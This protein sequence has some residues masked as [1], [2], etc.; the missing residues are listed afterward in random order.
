MEILVKIEHLRQCLREPGE[1]I[2][3]FVKRF[4]SLFSQIKKTLDVKELVK[5]CAIKNGL[6]AWFLSGAQCDTFE[7]V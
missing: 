1:E 6:A 5:I 7:Q 4:R 2:S 3:I